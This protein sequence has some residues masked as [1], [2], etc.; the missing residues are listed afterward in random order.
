M[1]IPIAEQSAG[2]R[3]ALR[4]WL[5]ALERAKTRSGDSVLVALFSPA[6]WPVAGRIQGDRGRSIHWR[7]VGDPAQIS[8]AR[9]QEHS[10]KD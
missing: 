3:M 2:Q 6:R 1:L 8:R 7:L 5:V 4:L 9:F 10:T